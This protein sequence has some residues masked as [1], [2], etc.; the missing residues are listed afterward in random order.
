MLFVRL[1]GPTVQPTSSH[2]FAAAIN[3]VLRLGAHY[4]DGFLA[5]LCHGTSYCAIAGYMI[6]AGHGDAKGMESIHNSS[7]ENSQSSMI[8]T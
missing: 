4:A 7:L 5:N 3:T 8:F 2:G 6:V 1:V